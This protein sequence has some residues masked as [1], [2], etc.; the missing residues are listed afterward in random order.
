MADTVEK[1]LRHRWLKRGPM[2]KR[3]IA[4]W[5]GVDYQ[6]FL[7]DYRKYLSYLDPYCTYKKTFYGVRIYDVFEE[8]FQ[9]DMNEGLREHLHLLLTVKNNDGLSDE[10]DLGKFINKHIPEYLK[11]NLLFLQSQVAKALCVMFGRVNHYGQVVYEGLYGYRYDIW[12]IKRGLNDSRELTPKEEEL[13]DEAIEL[14]F[15]LDEDKSKDPLKLAYEIWQRRQDCLR[16]LALLKEE[17]EWTKEDEE[18]DF[19]FLSTVSKVVRYFDDLRKKHGLPVEG[20]LNR[21]QK[22]VFK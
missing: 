9:G 10:K 14:A 1:R 13:L 18:R 11:A 8:V 16:M 3:A 4:A 2:T 22:Y 12:G 15:D 6:I 7:W 20:E 21:M 19:P 5:V 17:V